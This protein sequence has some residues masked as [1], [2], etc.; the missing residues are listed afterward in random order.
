MKLSWIF[1]GI[2]AVAAIASLARADVV[3]LKNGDKING[4]IGQISGGKMKFSSPVLGDLTID[5]TNVQ[6]YTTD[7]PAKI[8]PKAGPLVEDKITTGTEATVETAG[9]KSFT[10]GELKSI[11]PPPKEWTGSVLFA[12]AL[13]RGNTETFDLGLRINATLRRDDEKDDDRFTFDAAYNYG[14]TGTGNDADNTT[15]NWMAL[16]KYDRFWTEKLYGYAQMKVE[17]DLIAELNY[18]LSPGIG[19][20]YQWI[21]QPNMN[22]STEAGVSYVYEDYSSG[23]EDSFA[24]MRFAYHFDRQLAENAKLFHN[25]EYVGAF[26]D[27]GNYNLNGDVGLRTDL[28]KTFFAEFRFEYKRD[29]TPAEGALKNDMRYVAG[30]GWSF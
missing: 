8:Q 7:E 9:G 29:S 3:T 25:L 23:G 12:T 20:G 4:K 26:E 1:A 21:E 24:A 6:S 30:L 16:L 17:H 11:N 28:T 22:F 5:M 15:D 10:M 14:T 2:A 13:A 19:I 27:P 18:R